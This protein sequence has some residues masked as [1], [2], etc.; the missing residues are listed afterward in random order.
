MIAVVES[1][2]RTRQ[3]DAPKFE[4]LLPAIQKQASIAFRYLPLSD[5]EDMV[6][7]ATANSYLAYQR[8]VQRGKAHVAYASPLAQYAIRQIRAGRRVGNRQSSKD[9]MSAHAQRAH[10]ITV[11]RLDSVYVPR[12]RWEEMIFEDK[13]AG[14]SDVAAMR[15]DFAA[16]LKSLQ[17]MMRKIAKILATGETTKR[18]AKKFGVSQARVSQIRRELKQ[19]WQ[20]F[21]GELVVE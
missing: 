17:P 6:A 2:C 7:E 14:P 16:F 9:V 10:N 18:V 20:M 1:E 5:R 19:A 12:G 11:Q 3:D 8:L 4:E 15:I 21:Q 13:K